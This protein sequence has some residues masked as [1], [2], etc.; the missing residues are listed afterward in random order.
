MI[1]DILVGAV[2]LVSAII[3]F[4]RG[5]IREVLTIAGVV[6]GLAAAYAFGPMLT[7]TM[8]GW[9]GG[10]GSEDAPNKLFDIVPYTMVAQGLS[11]GAIF[12][13]VLIIISVAS[14]F[15]AETVKSVG[16]GA[17]DRTLGVFFGLA[18]GILV[19]GLL[20]LPVHMLAEGETKAGWFEDSRTHIYLEKTA[21]F[22]SKFLP[23]DTIDDIEESGTK[24]EE[25][26]DT[27]KKLEDMQ[28]LRKKA[29]EG[30]LSEDDK[31]KLQGY[32]EEFRDNMDQ[33]FEEKVRK[34]L[35]E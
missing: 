28:L 14:H 12:I 32:D 18:R 4:V 34:P 22:I 11:Y 13:I 16:L 5:F 6:G 2:L 26:M 30:T 20:Y 27:R 7:P 3:A 19:L 15:L 9:L 1:V 23:E 24:I 25:S 29:E 33:L 17:V 21:I 31:K 8:L 35:N 10:A